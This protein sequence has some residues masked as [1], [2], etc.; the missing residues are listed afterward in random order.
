MDNVREATSYS[1]NVV[2]EATSKQRKYQDIANGEV[3]DCLG[4]LLGRN[5][6]ACIVWHGNCYA[7]FTSKEKIQH[8][9]QKGETSEELQHATTAPNSPRN[10]HRGWGFCD[11]FFSGS[12]AHMFA[13]ELE[14]NV[15][16]NAPSSM[17]VRQKGQKQGL[18]FVT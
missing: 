6:D 14:K 4:D 17:C 5:D 11:T 1:R 18:F 16:Q 12:P 15:S 8:V 2:S 13:G 10:T 3:I 7:Q 9:Q